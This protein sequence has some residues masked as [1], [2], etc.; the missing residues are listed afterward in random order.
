MS[1][2]REVNEIVRQDSRAWIAGLGDE[3]GGG[4]WI[5][6]IM[7]QLGEPNK[8]ELDKV[9]AVRGRGSLGRA[10]IQRWAEEIRGS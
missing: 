5:S 2:D 7:K 9:S 6:A 10:A 4:A 3:G 1:Y 8:D